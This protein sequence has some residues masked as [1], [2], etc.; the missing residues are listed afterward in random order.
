V[1]AVLVDGT[2]IEWSDLTPALAEAAGGLVLEELVLHRTLQTECERR[3]LSPSDAAIESERQLLGKALTAAANVPESESETI[4]AKVR[5]SRGLGDVRFDGLLRRN[6][7]LRALVRSG[8]LEERVAA[9]SDDDLRQAYSLKYGSKVR[10]RLILVRTE[11]LAAEA[12]RRLHGEGRPAEGFGDVASQVSVD[13][14]AARGGLLDP[15]SLDDANYPVAVRRVLTQLE[16]GE[17]SEPIAIS[18]GT[19]EGYAIVKFEERVSA[20]AGAPAPEACKE[21]LR[22]EVQ[23]VRER[24]AMDRLARRLVA[25]TKVTIFDRTLD[26]SWQERTGQPAK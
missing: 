18:W 20:P 8:K 12:L 14:S 13:Q 5:L 7:M 6:A 10:A 17:I 2:R 15:F 19:S 24:A 1:P 25:E 26:R 3:G 22:T 21:E 9:V 23:I 16:P 4:I 11:P